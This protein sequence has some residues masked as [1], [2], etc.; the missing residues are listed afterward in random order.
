MRPLRRIVCLLEGVVV[1][2]G[3]A[4]GEDDGHGL[5]SDDLTEG[6]RFLAPGAFAVR[7]ATEWERGLAERRV[8]VSAEERRARIA[9][10]IAR[11][12]GESRLR[13]AE[14][15]PALLDEV[16]GLVEW[17]V[18]LMGTIDEHFMDLPP[19]VMRV[20][21]RLNQRYFA[22]AEADGAFARKF[23]FA[24]NI[25]AADG[26][27]AIVAGNERVLRARLADARHFWD[28]DRRTGLEARVPKLEHV[29][30][31]ARLGSQGARVRRIVDLARAIAP[32][33]GA[34]PAL[35]ERAALL[36]KADLVSGMVGEFPELQGVMGRYYAQNDGEPASVATRDPR[37]LRA[38]GT[39]RRGADRAGLD[40]G[41]ACG[42]ARYARAVSSRSARSRPVRTTPMRCGAPRSASS[43]SSARTG[44]G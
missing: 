32:A 19:E 12:A 2:F 23:A 1:P 44:S 6:H 18:V 11:L 26:G 39:G 10:G 33:I 29:T 22:L 4:E 27:A 31:H 24:A 20:T 25:E 35:A 16:A 14:T 30:F 15:D 42:Q 38:Q 5:V 21:M 43:A 17:P 13:L 28:L 37:A 8:I 34:P 36:A 7:S 9:A 3:L 40:R 41:R